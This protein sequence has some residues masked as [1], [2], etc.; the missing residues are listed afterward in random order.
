MQH[1]NACDSELLSQLDV[2]TTEHS[3]AQK[4]EFVVETAS[5]KY[6]VSAMP[7][8]IVRDV[9]E[10][11][12]NSA[13]CTLTLAGGVLTADKTI[14]SQ[15]VVDQTV[16]VASQVAACHSQTQTVLVPSTRM[17]DLQL[18]IDS[19]PP[20]PK[21]QDFTV[22]GSGLACCCCRDTFVEDRTR[23]DAAQQDVDS[24]PQVVIVNI[25]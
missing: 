18:E 3:Q 15:G 1:H 10:L 9:A 25:V 23:R 20:R 24:A 13:P 4:V 22:S 6:T 21:R 5:S 2:A 17:R 12:D 11:L 7:E 19:L 16:L 8:T 14:E